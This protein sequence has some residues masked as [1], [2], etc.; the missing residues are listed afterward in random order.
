MSPTLEHSRSRNKSYN[1]KN[2]FVIFSNSFLSY[3]QFSTCGI[4]RRWGKFWWSSGH[5]CEFDLYLNLTFDLN[6]L[7]LCQMR[8]LSGTPG[9]RL[10]VCAKRGVPFGINFPQR[11]IFQSFVDFAQNNIRKYL[12]TNTKWYYKKLLL[13]KL[14]SVN[15][16]LLQ[17][18]KNS[19]VKW[20]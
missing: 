15:K 2:N 3:K 1:N 4:C 7:D 19:I 13:A 10:H 14:F 20:V 18:V 9:V 17:N 5:F 6:D 11:P 8:P 12:I 16:D